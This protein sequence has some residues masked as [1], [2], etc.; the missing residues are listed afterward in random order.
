MRKHVYMVFICMFLSFL[1]NTVYA[2][3]PYTIKVGYIG[4]ETHPT[5]QAMR[6]EFV[7]SVEEGSKGQVKVE[8]YPNAQ[9]GG[10]RELCESV[11]MGMTQMAIP[12]TSALAG[13]DKR[14]QVLDLPEKLRLKQ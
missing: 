3:T 10:D 5:M 7:H 4:S 12:S 13:F 8:L 11:Q 6:E 14:V 1:S 2:K 9:L